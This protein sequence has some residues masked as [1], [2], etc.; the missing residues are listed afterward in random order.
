[1]ATFLLSQSL[2]GSWRLWRSARQASL[3]RDWRLCGWPAVSSR[4]ELGRP[5]DSRP[6]RYRRPRPGYINYEPIFLLIKLAYSLIFRPSMFVRSR[7]LEQRG[8]KSAPD[9]VPW[10]NIKRFCNSQDCPEAGALNAPFKITNERTVQSAFLVEIHLGHL[11]SFASFPH[12]LPER[13]LWT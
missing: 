3:L 5:F 4:T 6:T 10:S 1:M 9:Q 7:E 2:R 8:F 11:D 13:P 12:G